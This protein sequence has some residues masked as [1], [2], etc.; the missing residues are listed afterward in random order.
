MKK[1]SLI[2]FLL[3]STSVYAA[4]VARGPAPIPYIPPPSFTWTGPYMGAAVGYGWGNFAN[5]IAGGD[6]SVDLPASSSGFMGGLYGGYN[7]QLGNVVL[8]LESDIMYSALR[9]SIDANGHFDTGGG[10]VPWAAR[11][12]N[13]LSW[14]G[15]MRGRVGY[16]FGHFMPYVTGGLAYGNFKSDAIGVVGASSVN[17]SLAQS[18]SGS[19]TKTGWTAGAGLE[20]AILSNLTARLEYL[21][22]DLGTTKWT[23]A[24]DPEITLSTRHKGDTVRVGVGF[25]F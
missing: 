2:A 21:H 3:S 4:D 20:Y 10:S 5:T 22:W 17:S 14:L 6:L 18:F 15:T 7:Y 9:G 23:V 11:V 19:S 1:L 8:G 16:A 25:K 13:K 12:D 24:A